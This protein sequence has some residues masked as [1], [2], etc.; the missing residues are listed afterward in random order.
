MKSAAYIVLLLCICT[1]DALSQQPRVFSL[2]AR[3]TFDSAPYSNVI[4]DIKISGDSIWVGTHKG[5]DLT[6]TNGDAWR[7]FAETDGIKELAVSALAYF[8]GA[9]WVAETSNLRQDGSDVPVGEGFFYSTDGGQNWAHIPQ[10][11]EP[12]GATIDTLLYGTN[13]IRTLA[14]TV[15]PGNITYDIALT[16]NAVWTANFYGMLRKSTNHGQTWQR[17]VLPPDNLNSISPNDTLNFD[18]S[19]SI[20]DLGLRESLNHRLFSVYASDDSTI[21]AG[22]AGGINKSTDGGVSWRKFSHQNQQQPISGNFVVGLNEQQ[23]N[24]R[25]ILWA[26]TVNAVDLDEKRGLSFSEDGGETWKTTLLGEF[27]HNIA[28]KDSIVYA[29]S[30]NGLFRSSNFGKSWLRTGTIDDP[31]N[32]QRITSSRVTTAATKGDTVWTGWV[33]G[34]AYTIDSPSE[35]FG[36]RWK[37]FRTSQQVENSSATYSYP[38]PFSP[39]DEVVRLHYSTS[40][41]NAPVTIRI[42]NFAMQPVKTLIQNA[43]RLGSYEHDEIWDGRDDFNNRIAN[44]VYFYQVEVEGLEPAWGKIY[45]VE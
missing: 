32:Q 24:G 18:L 19:P 22:T 14:V 3:P 2:D 38:S 12:E 15:T 36:T 4:N 42:F 40:G 9:L 13:K 44:G 28:F 11:K 17:V 45:V 30:D 25:R 7:H 29:T 39:D 31:T 33:D 35:A 21:W 34:L 37:V 10:P 5:L 8:N 6:T 27:V 1:V 20:G 26:A 43:Q 16:R 23:W 41:R